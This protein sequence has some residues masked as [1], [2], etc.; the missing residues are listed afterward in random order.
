MDEQIYI[1]EICQCEHKKHSSD[2][3]KNLLAVEFNDWSNL[4]DHAQNVTRMQIDRN[5]A[6]QKELLA[7]KKV[8][9]DL[10]DIDAFTLQVIFRNYVTR[11]HEKIYEVRELSKKGNLE[12]VL[13][14]RGDITLFTSQL[15]EMQ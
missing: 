1:C 2:Y 9:D 7:L 12:G 6:Q 5:V 8:N 13:G 4:M 14:L 10:P 15:Q 3:I 11:L